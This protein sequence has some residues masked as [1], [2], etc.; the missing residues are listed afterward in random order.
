M[1]IL[2]LQIRNHLDPMRMHEVKCF[3][4]KLE[5]YGDYEMR[6]H[7]LIRPQGKAYLDDLDAVMVGGS[8]DYGCVNNT[9]PWYLAARELLLEVVDRGIPMFCSCFGHQALAD[10]LGGE[11]ITDRQRSELGT[12][13]IS[14][15][16]EGKEDPLFS[17]MPARFKAQLGHNDHVVKLPRGAVHLAKSKLCKIQA[18]RLK[19]KPVYATQFHPEI[20]YSENIERARAYLHVYEGRLKTASR[21]EKCFAPSP[22]T[23]T[24]IARFLKLV[25][26]GEI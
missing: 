21:L 19:D 7:C 3:C 14:L 12:F 1:K 4:D 18:Y 10:A 17:A 9:Q 6:I 24:L 26:R 11:V 25:E 16:K 2:L 20:K 15:T 8:G 13:S 22:H 23:E 5:R